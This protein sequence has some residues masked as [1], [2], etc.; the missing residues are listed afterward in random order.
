M[1]QLAIARASLLTAV[2]GSFG[3]CRHSEMRFCFAKSQSHKE[4]GR[5]P[6]GHANPGRDYCTGWQRRGAGRW[7]RPGLMACFGAVV[8]WVTWVAAHGFSTA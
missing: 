6:G 2:C 3:G 5:A 4:I 8:N 1:A 7:Y